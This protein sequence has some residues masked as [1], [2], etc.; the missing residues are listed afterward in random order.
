MSTQVII[1]V[2]VGGLG[3][4]VRAILGAFG[5]QYLIVLAGGM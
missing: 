5:I 1:Y 3:T 4:L 2:L